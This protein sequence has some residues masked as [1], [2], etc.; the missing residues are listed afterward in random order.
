ML[1][2]NGQEGWREVIIIAII[3][4]LAVAA[5]MS[6]DPPSGFIRT[7][8]LLIGGL[9]LATGGWLIAKSF[10]AEGWSAMAVAWVFGAVG[11]DILLPLLKKWLE[12]RLPRS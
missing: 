2:P 8:W 11:S 12:N 6:Q 10:G 7:A 3:S 1:S 5:R 9:G 4:F